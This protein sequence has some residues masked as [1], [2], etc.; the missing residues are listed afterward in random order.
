MARS[1]LLVLGAMGGVFALVACSSHLSRA[2]AE[3]II[4]KNTKLPT[5][6]SLVITSQYLRMGNQYFV[7]TG[8]GTYPPPVDAQELKFLMSLMEMRDTRETQGPFMVVD[9]VFTD[10]SRD[11]ALENNG[12][13]YRVKSCDLVFGEITGIQVFEQSNLASVEYTLRRTN[14]TPFGEFYRQRDPSHYPEVIPLKV[15]LQRYDDG[16]RLK[17]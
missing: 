2:T 7:N 1:Q 15:E 6:D 16:W 5:S 14:W 9:M 11:L 4:V 10:K 13:S 8:G 3:S 12:S 17:K